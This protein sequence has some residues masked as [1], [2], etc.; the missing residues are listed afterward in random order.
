[1]NDTRAFLFRRRLRQPV[2]QLV[3]RRDRAG[4]GRAILFGP[5]ADLALE[6]VTRLAVFAEASGDMVD[7]VEMGQ[8]RIRRVI[9]RGAIRLVEI[10]QERIPEDP[11]FHEIHHIE[12]RADD[13]AVHAQ[14]LHG[15][16]REARRPQLAHHLELTV[17][18]VGRGQELARRLA[19]QDIALFRRGELV[20]RVGLPAL[21]LADG[22]RPGIAVHMLRHPRGKGTFIEG[23]GIG[24]L[25]GAGE[26]FVDLAHSLR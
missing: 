21:E 24:D 11:A 2:D 3:H 13:L 6:I 20:G 9:D 8:C 19:P 4:L 23:E 26:L 5:A 25:F 22:Q 18:G 1:M 16:G 7:R 14:A 15:R 10:G 12:F 17:H